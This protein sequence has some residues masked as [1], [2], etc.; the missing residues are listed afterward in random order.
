MCKRRVLLPLL[1]SSVL[2]SAM[3]EQ[4]ALYGWAVDRIV[5]STLGLATYILYPGM[6][7]T[8]P[9]FQ[10]PKARRTEQPETGEAVALNEQVGF[11]G[12]T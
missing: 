10:A 8:K 4:R 5:V 7:G 3:W 9:P 6:P 1:P 12:Q 2:V 11:Y